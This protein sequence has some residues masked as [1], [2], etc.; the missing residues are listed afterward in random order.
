MNGAVTRPLRPRTRVLKVPS[1]DTMSPRTSA[2]SAASHR[3]PVC[4]LKFRLCSLTRCRPFGPEA[5]HFL[6]SR[7]S[8]PKANSV[9]SPFRAAPSP[10]TATLVVWSLST[11]MQP[12]PTLRPSL[13]LVL[14]LTLRALRQT[15]RSWHQQHFLLHRMTQL[16]LAS[17]TA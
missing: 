1:L 6:T 12:D 4:G 2:N 15:A 5:S 14:E 10:R 17:L 13:M 11:A 8:L 9:W 3:R 7:P 16:A